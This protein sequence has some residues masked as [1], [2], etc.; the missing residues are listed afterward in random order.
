VSC[1]DWTLLTARRE[2]GG[3]DP[4][5][6]TEAMQ[7][8]DSCL[9]CRREALAADP[10]LVF[11]RLPAADLDAAAERSEV[12]A[13]CQAVTAMRTARRLEARQSFA[14][15]RRWAAAAVLALAALSMGRDKA[16]RLEVERA[17]PAAGGLARPVL[18]RSAA[19]P[20]IDVLNRPD[21]HVY[22]I[23]DGGLSV[24]MVV[25]ESLDL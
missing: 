3:A 18:A 7:H 12:E 2:R 22:H 6:W 23:N 16:P 19:A 9:L 25:D 15:W 17:A 20:T 11:R 5:G 14:G 8:F 10:L 4:A 24:T 21:A 13:V 1:P